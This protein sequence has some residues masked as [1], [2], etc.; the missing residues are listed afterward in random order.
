MRKFQIPLSIARG[1]LI[2]PYAETGTVRF[3]MVQW[4]VSFTIVRSGKTEG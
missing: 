1:C 3:N 4:H 2:G